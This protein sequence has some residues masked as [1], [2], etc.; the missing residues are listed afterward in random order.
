MA[1]ATDERKPNFNA[2]TNVHLPANRT[3]AEPPA[4]RTDRE[5]VREPVEQRVQEERGRSP[6]EV[7]ADQE[8]RQP[9][10][11]TDDT[12]DKA[13]PK[14][15]KVR[16]QEFSYEEIAKRPD[17]VEALAITAERYPQLQQKYQ[18][19]L[20][21][22]KEKSLERQPEKQLEPEPP[23]VITQA[24]IRQKFDPMVAQAVAMKYMEPDFAEAYPDVSAG[25]MYFRTMIE[26]L[27]EVVGHL[28]NWVG[29]EIQIRNARS[30]ESILD[31]AISEVAAKASDTKDRTAALYKP[32]NDA[33]TREDFKEWLKEEVD[34]K[35]ES[36]NAKNIDRFWKAFNAAALLEMANTEK[37]ETAPQNRKLARGDGASVRS[38]M[39]P[40]APQKPS[41]LQNMIAQTGKFAPVDS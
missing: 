16:G 20:E 6:A 34:P 15:I 11:T 19:V 2:L 39:P 13:K 38:G 3:N 35:M 30:N 12:D 21:A 10:R 18:S 40:E 29:S 23:A 28:R 27:D 1:E 31:R 26:A 33:Q 4:T 24:Q 25:M 14:K 5:D 17:L 32:L 9:V 37:K 36:I 41:M 22:I 7:L 8:D